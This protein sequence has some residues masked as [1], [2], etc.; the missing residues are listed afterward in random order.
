MKEVIGMA[1]ERYSFI[2]PKGESKGDATN[3]LPR[4]T[5]SVRAKALARVL[6]PG[7]ESSQGKPKSIHSGDNFSLNCAGR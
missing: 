4:L 5:Q 3:S 7:D 2:C 6:G 1:T